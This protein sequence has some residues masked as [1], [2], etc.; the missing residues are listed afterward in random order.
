M[1]RMVNAILDIS[2]LEEGKLDLKRGECDVVS[3]AREAVRVT[4]QFREEIKVVV[5]TPSEPLSAYVDADLIQRVFQNLLDNAYKYS[6]EGGEIRIA[7]ETHGE[8]V[9]ALVAD[10]GPG[11]AEEYHEKI[12][13][14]FWQ[15]EAKKQGIPT[16]STGLGLAFCKLVVEAHGG[17]IWVES[18]KGKGSIFRF[19]LPKSR[20]NMQSAVKD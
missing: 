15:V 16:G 6:P 13:E 17:R 11:I 8:R 12:F 2:R 3:L 7:M 20:T 10:S 18:N 14:K 9:A 4:G 19:V 5:E 1:I